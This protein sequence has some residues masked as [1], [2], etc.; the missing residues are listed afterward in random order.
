MAI[1]HYCWITISVRR[2]N[3]IWGKL[4]GQNGSLKNVNKVLPPIRCHFGQSFVIISGFMFQNSYSRS[5]IVNKVKSNSR[6]TNNWSPIFAEWEQIDAQTILFSLTALLKSFGVKFWQT[7]TWWWRWLEKLCAASHIDKS[8][9]K[10]DLKSCR[11]SIELLN[12]RTLLYKRAKPNSLCCCD[13]FILGDAAAPSVGV[14]HNFQALIR[15]RLQ[16]LD[17]GNRRR[18]SHG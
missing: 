8:V 9:T 10:K 4:E 17:C 1:W 16:A 14:G 18:L 11:K 5:I 3:I 12:R 13:G 7:D 15:L 6:A 2:T